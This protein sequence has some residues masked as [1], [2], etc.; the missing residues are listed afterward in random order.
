MQR[1]GQGRVGQQGVQAGHNGVQLGQHLLY[2][3]CHLGHLVHQATVDGSA[4]GVAGL[5][6]LGRGCAHN[7]VHLDIAH[8]VALYLGTRALGYAQLLICTKLDHYAG[9][10]SVVEVDGLDRAHLEA[11]GEYGA[12]CR[13]TTD[14]GKLGKVHAVRGEQTL[15]LQKIHAKEQHYYSHNSG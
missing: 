5:N 2:G 9:P 12:R 7:Q 3:R 6:G 1:L 11:I 15:A 4:D 8:H 10:G 13:E 14:V